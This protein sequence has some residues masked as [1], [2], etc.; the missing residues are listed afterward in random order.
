MSYYP[1]AS[2]GQPYGQPY[3]PVQPIQP[4]GQ[5]YPSAQPFP[6]AYPMTPRAPQRN[7]MMFV[8]SIILTAGGGLAIFGGLILLGIVGLINQLPSSNYFPPDLM[9][10]VIVGIMVSGISGVIELIVGIVGI[11]NAARPD[12]ADMLLV[13][14][15]ILCVVALA[16]L[17]ITFRMYQQLMYYTGVGMANA[18]TSVTAFVLPVLF[19]IG[20]VNMKKQPPTF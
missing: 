17:V 14:G 18:F 11:R 16:N 3:Q 5:P 8:V 9:S 15:I 4:Y 20:A 6:Y 7:M 1:P 2:D 13:L 12:K 10:L 19:V